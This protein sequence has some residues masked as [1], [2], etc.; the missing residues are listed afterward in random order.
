MKKITKLCALLLVFS[1][2]LLLCACSGSGSS[3][4]HVW[5]YRV[6]FEKAVF[7]VGDTE[8]LE[9]LTGGMSDMLNAM[10]EGLTMDMVLDLKSDNS[11][12]FYT[13]EES[14][15]AA[16][17][18]MVD[19]LG[20]KLPEIMAPIL[21]IDAEQFSATLSAMGLSTDYFMESI[22][23]EMDTDK[24]LEELKNS[25][26]NGTYRYENGKLY[27]TLEGQTEDPNA[28]LTVE[29][30]GKEMRVTAINNVPDFEKYSSMLPMVFTR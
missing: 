10:V 21:G 30:N 2:L 16:M 4:D 26:I 22:R 1:V 24:L 9:E 25:A 6:D 17:D 23:K 14:A 7:S 13:D 29:V 20:K 18:G 15:K 5:R 12:S 3:I 28:Y 19:N 8:G 11:F 27:L